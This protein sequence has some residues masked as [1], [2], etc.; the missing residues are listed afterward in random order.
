MHVQIKD[1]SREPRLYITVSP[2]GLLGIEWNRDASYDVQRTV[3]DI[4]HGSYSSYEKPYQGLLH[5]EE[6]QTHKKLGL[7]RSQDRGYGH[8]IL[9]LSHLL[10]RIAEKHTRDITHNRL[11]VRSHSPAL[12]HSDRKCH[13]IHA[14]IDKSGMLGT[15]QGDHHNLVQPEQ[16]VSKHP[17]TNYRGEAIKLQQGQ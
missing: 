12:R 11:R 5:L 4:M 15:D 13:A 16:Q 8:L 1:G 17:C 3:T 2:L 9:S 6:H 7:P 14:G 10:Q